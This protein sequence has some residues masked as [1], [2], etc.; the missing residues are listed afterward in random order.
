MPLRSGNPIP[1]TSSLKSFWWLF[2]P[3]QR[4]APRAGPGRD[5]TLFGGPP[6]KPPTQSGAQ[7]GECPPGGDRL[8]EP[9]RDG[10]GGG[11]AGCS[12]GS[13]PG[14]GPRGPQGPAALDGIVRPARRPDPN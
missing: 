11:W 14:E 9:L 1:K 8:G 4:S 7:A 5:A 2:F 12:G 13:R 10:A 6:A 3:A